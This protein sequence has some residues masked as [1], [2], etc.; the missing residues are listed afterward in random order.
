MNIRLVVLFV[1]AA[2]ACSAAG[3]ELPEVESVFGMDYVGDSSYLAL[4][5]PVPDGEVFAGVRWYNNDS[6][7]AIP[8]IRAQAGTSE[9]PSSIEDAVVVVEDAFGGAMAWSEVDFGQAITSECGGLYLYFKLPEGAV[10]RDE[11]AGG[12]FGMGYCLGEGART[13]WLSEDGLSWNPMAEGF[14]MAAEAVVEANKSAHDVLVLRLPESISE[15]SETVADDDSVPL[16][17]FPMRA[18]PNP[19]NPS[20]KI[21]F[22]TSASGPVQLDVYDIRGRR[23]AELIRRTMAPGEHSVVWDGRSLNGASCAS[24]AYFVRLVSVDGTTSER[25]VLLK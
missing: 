3:A 6:L 15:S 23:V 18:T 21:E 11:G 22:T 5:V 25:V 9:W 13:S 14:K 16:A 7:T 17:A 2:W 8:E 19:F 20:T 24:G 10:I 12:G 1:V 4:W